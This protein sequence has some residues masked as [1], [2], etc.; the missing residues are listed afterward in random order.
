MQRQRSQGMGGLVLAYILKGLL[1]DCEI[2]A[3]LRITFVWSSICHISTI[4]MSN[5]SKILRRYV[6]CPRRECLVRLA[7]CS[8]APHCSTEIFVNPGDGH[9][10]TLSNN[11]KSPPDW[12]TPTQ[13]EKYQKCSWFCR[14]IWDF[15]EKIATSSPPPTTSPMMGLSM[16]MAKSMKSEAIFRIPNH[17]SK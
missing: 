5:W 7:V 9:N 4:N 16:F 8:D 12:I 11:I 1:C 14:S 3:I 15:D 13:Y 6:F 10:I 2:F 17:F